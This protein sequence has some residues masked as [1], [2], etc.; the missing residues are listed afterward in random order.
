MAS[1]V[2]FC[3]ATTNWWILL[4]AGSREA[5]EHCFWRPAYGFTAIKSRLVKNVGHYVSE[6]DV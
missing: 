5:M 6:L 3:R 2:F 4:S 1:Y